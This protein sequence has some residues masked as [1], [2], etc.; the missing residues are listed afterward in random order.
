M[1]LLVNIDVPELERGVSF[2]TRAFDLRVT[3]R[4]GSDVAELEG[5]ACKIFL[6]AKAPG[7]K[8]TDAPTLTR[9]YER[10]W[11]PLHF[12][13]EVDDLD[14]AVARAVEAGARVET[15]AKT[16]SWGKIAML[17]DPF[18]HGFCL[19]QLLGRGYDELPW[20]PVS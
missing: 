20:Q 18:G 12:D 11:T 13:V 14:S 1:N 7:S 10:H 15:P 6:L 17:V 19:L 9:D 5:A 16:Y 4:I 8:P 2:Y 3:R